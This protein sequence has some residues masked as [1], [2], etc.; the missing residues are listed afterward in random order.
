MFL[1]IRMLFVLAVS[2]YTVRVVLR[3]LDV[4]DYGI[5]TAIGGVV[6]SLSF[7]SQI[8]SSAS[9]R[10]FAYEIG[11]QN[12]ERLNKI[13]N[14]LFL[15]YIGIILLI[16]GISETL[17]LW[18][19][20]CKMSIPAER[21]DAAYWVF[22]FSLLAFAVTIITNPFI[23]LI[24]A[25]E[26]MN[27]FAYIGIAEVLLKLAVAG[28]LIVATVDK[29]K[30]Y[31][32]LMFVVSCIIGI[33][34]YGICRKRFP[35]IKLQRSWDNN[36]FKSIFSY[37]SWTLFGTVAG[38]CN[39]QGINVL[40][41]VFY[42]PVANTA[43]AVGYQVSTGVSNFA[44]SFYTAVRPQLTKSYAIGDFAYMNQLFLFSS[45]TIFALLYAIILPLM[46]ET[47][48]ILKLW[49]GD[50]KPYMVYFTQL[51][52]VYTI[53]ICIGNPITTIAQASGQVKR[54]HGIVDGF[55][56]VAL[57][58]SYIAFKLGALPEVTF[59]ITIAVFI[60]AHALRLIVVRNI[61]PIRIA[62]Y[63]KC[64]ILPAVMIIVVTILLSWPVRLGINNTVGQ[65]L[66][67][68]TISIVSSCFCSYFILFNQEEKSIF[69]SLFRHSKR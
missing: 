67:V 36:I 50:V 8:L 45:K 57:P 39:N 31:A 19:L 40:L 44:S 9:Q 14:T 46:L 22:Q 59:Y 29:L 18:F 61:V 7:L 64:F 52:L 13:F 15:T 41:N 32:V 26:H 47:D 51:M 12:Y 1:Y 25:H 56:L 24:I 63:V 42:G 35:H 60:I 2:L 37:S 48:I 54:Y 58:L 38:V 62:E 65:L 68:T 3:N 17:G 6:L 55:G 30:L 16:I 4:V 33:L 66:C 10:F 28:L 69:R 34:Y 5:Y 20:S 23:A 53:I 49:L 11:L 21:M 27:V 43:Y